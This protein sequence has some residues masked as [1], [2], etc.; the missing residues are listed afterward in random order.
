MSRNSQILILRYRKTKRFSFFVSYSLWNSS[1]A[2]ILRTNCP[3]SMRFS[4]NLKL[5]NTQ[6]ANANKLNLIFF[7]FRLILLDRITNFKHCFYN[8]HCNTL[9]VEQRRDTSWSSDLWRWCLPL[10]K[11]S[12]SFFIIRSTLSDQNFMPWYTYDFACF[13]KNKM[14]HVFPIP[15]HSK[16]YSCSEIVLWFGLDCIYPLSK[17]SKS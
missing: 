5:N 6:I 2:C 13:N 9:V 4:P 8:W 14:F 17:C 16:L 1:T 10:F 7:D 15:S 3:I 12:C 11:A